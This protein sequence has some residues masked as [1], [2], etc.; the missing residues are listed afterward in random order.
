MERLHSTQRLKSNLDHTA[1]IEYVLLFCAA[2]PKG[3]ACTMAQYEE[4]LA[5]MDKLCRAAHVVIPLDQMAFWAQK[6]LEDF[7]RGLRS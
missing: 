3:I 2:S 6:A 1:P 4:A 5:L 7:E